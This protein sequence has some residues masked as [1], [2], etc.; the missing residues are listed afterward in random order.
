ME[1]ESKIQ[2]LKEY[3]RCNDIVY[4]ISLYF[5]REYMLYIRKHFNKV[6]GGEKE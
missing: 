2:E 3:C 4:T 6:D 5:F 1:K